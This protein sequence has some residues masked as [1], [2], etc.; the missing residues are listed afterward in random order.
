[1]TN[2]TDLDQKPLWVLVG[3]RGCH[4][5]HLTSDI[6]AAQFEYDTT[7]SRPEIEFTSLCGKTITHTIVQ[8]DTTKS[9]NL[10]KK[11]IKRTTAKEDQQ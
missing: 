10:C 8:P 2:Y 11:C 5:Y 1:M 6:R 3:A 4:S 7:D 9:A